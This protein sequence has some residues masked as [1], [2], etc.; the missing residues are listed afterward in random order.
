MIPNNL[1]LVKKSWNTFSNSVN[2]NAEMAR[3]E[4]MSSL[5]QLAKNEIKG[6]RPEGQKATA[7]KPPMNRTGNLRR[8]IRGEKYQSGFGTYGAVVGPTMV[9]ARAVELGGEY[10]PKSW[11]GTSAMKGFPYMEPAYKKFQ[12]TVMPQIVAKYFA[13]GL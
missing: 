2:A 3:N 7:G 4:M 13:K 12:Q 8:S 1:K 6:R 9:Y 10:A 11:H 5:I